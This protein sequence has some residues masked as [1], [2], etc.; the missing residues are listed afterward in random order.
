MH[1]DAAVVARE[2]TAE[3]AFGQFLL[4]HDAPGVAQQNLEQ[5]ELGAG[6]IQRELCQCT[7]RFSG[8]IAPEWSGADKGWLWVANGLSPCARR[9]IALTRAASSRGVH[10]F[11]T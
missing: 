4:A 7:L 8:L 1:I 6:E 2:W 5:I 9:R 11:G 3:G 10:G